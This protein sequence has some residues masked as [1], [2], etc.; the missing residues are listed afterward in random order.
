MDNL[1]SKISTKPRSDYLG[2]GLLHDHCQH[3]HVLYCLGAPTIIEGIKL[4]TVRDDLISKI[5]TK[6]QSDD[7]TTHCAEKLPRR[8]RKQIQIHTDS[9]WIID[10]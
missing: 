9:H 5:C 2:N 1:N 3:Q 7:S 8:G 6:P 4:T 10:F